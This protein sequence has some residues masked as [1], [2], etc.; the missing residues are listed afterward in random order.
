MSAFP[1]IFT[2]NE[3]VGLAEEERYDEIK[4][5]AVEELEGVFEVEADEID[6][7]I[8]R[9][10]D[11]FGR[12]TED[13]EILVNP[14]YDS[15]SPE[16]VGEAIYEEAAHILTTQDTHEKSHD[17]RRKHRDEW[18][19]WEN[20]ANEI[21]GALPRWGE[22]W[23]LERSLNKAEDH[24]S[25]V[26]E[27]QDNYDGEGQAD[28]L[29]EGAI[30]NTIIH[31]VGYS[32]SKQAQEQGYEAS[33]IAEMSY[34]KLYEEF[35]DEAETIREDLLEEYGVFID[36]DA[37]AAT[38]KPELKEDAVDSEQKKQEIR[39]ALDEGKYRIDKGTV[40]VKTEDDNEYSLPD[41][42]FQIEIQEPAFYIKDGNEGYGKGRFP[43]E[44]EWRQGWFGFGE[45][46]IKEDLGYE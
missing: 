43:F 32:I 40:S 18:N 36:W 33:E 16:I 19:L 27:E 29:D 28:N 34:Q 14:E 5:K 7:E 3:I 46:A 41:E 20:A 44:G 9:S 38:P 35:E 37:P 12:Y 4:D 15:G 42:A 21:L 1:E 8:D 31:H 17:E 30:R 45:E 2:E 6:L 22:K 26:R 10:I 13:R 11:T 25:E 24:L 23:D 39:Q